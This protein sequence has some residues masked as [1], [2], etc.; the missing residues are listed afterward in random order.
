MFGIL[1]SQIKCFQEVISIGHA[2]Y[3]EHEFLYFRT[4]QWYFLVA[5]N[6]FFYGEMLPST[7]FIFFRTGKYLPVLVRFHLLISF[8][9]YVAGIV[10]FV[11]TLRKGSYRMQ[12]KMFGWTHVTLLL[13]VTQSH[14]LVQNLFEGLF[15]FLIPLLLVVCNDIMA[16]IFG[17]FFGRTSLI[18]LSP[19][20][21]W[22]GF[23][24][25]FFSTIVFG[26]LFA[27]L[28]ARYQF[29]ACPIEYNEDSITAVTISCK[30][31]YIFTQQP[32]DVPGILQ[33]LFGP[34]VTLFP[35]Q[36]HAVMM[37]TFASSVAPFGGFLAS[38]FKRAF[39]V[40]DFDNLIPGHG[41]LMDRFDCQYL[42]ATFVYVYISAFV[43]AVRPNYVLRL[44]MSM[45]PDEQVSVYNQIQGYM[46]E[47]NL[48]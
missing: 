14:L 42:M 46:K 2:K 20:K 28:L 37:A 48:I 25:A 45:T 29:F 10:A 27:N 15:W 12:F 39:D 7:F 30:P 24:G 34:T 21:T 35:A 9:M 26:F 36:I 5:A 6:Y 17:F 1:V 19:K 3:R 38:G 18:Q 22:E 16:Y 47:G 44:F 40:K 32:Y 13:I 31:S 33:S 4:L 11:L 43:H 23:I 8:L 41:G